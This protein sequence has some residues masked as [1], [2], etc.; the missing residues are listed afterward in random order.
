MHLIVAS[1]M[2]N[3]PK[4]TIV[5]AYRPAFTGGA[6]LAVAVYGVLV[7]TQGLSPLMQLILSVLSGASAHAGALWYWQ[8]NDVMQIQTIMRSAMTRR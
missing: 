1:R 6:C 5:Q 7:L 3:I 2:F 4:Y 8:K